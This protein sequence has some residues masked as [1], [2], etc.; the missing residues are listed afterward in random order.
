M[1]VIDQTGILDN[2]NQKPKTLAKYAH[3]KKFLRHVSN[4]IDTV[5][6]YSGS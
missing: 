4:V 2:K 3:F 6:E 1:E 5:S